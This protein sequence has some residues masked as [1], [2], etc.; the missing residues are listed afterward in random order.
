M[1]SGGNTFMITN[2]ASGTTTMV[3][4]GTGADTVDVQATGGK[5]TVNTGGG[6]NLNVVN[7]GSK[8]PFTGGIVNNIQ[9]A[10]TVVGNGA[11]TMN[12]DDTGSTTAKTGT[13]TAT[14]LTG[15]NMGPSGITYSGLSILNLSLGSGGATGNAF[16]IAVDAG[17]NLPA[18]TNIVGGSAVLDTLNGSWARDFNGTLNLSRFATSGFM[19]GNNFNGALTDINPGYIKSITIGG[20]L[21][22]AATL[23]VN[24]ASDPAIPPTPVGLLGDI[25]TMIVGGSIAGLVEVTGNIT[26]LDVGPANTPTANDVNDVSGRVIAGGS[27]MTASVSGNVSGLIQSNFTVNSLYIGGS[28][29]PSGTFTLPTPFPARISPAQQNLNILTIGSNLAGTVFVPGTLG[30]ASLG[31]SLL[32]TG[33]MSVGNLDSLTIEQDLDGR[34][35]VLGRST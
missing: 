6:A 33:V 8:A 35:D 20:S 15:L 7:V 34:L 11:D 1:G 21:N 27:L 17:T 29:T 25:G 22:A 32:D 30:T 3:N 4:S 18:T 14:T 9:G 13:L 16:N 31:G 26:T 19:V 10:L 2:T 12:V 28:L 23:V 5:T 24:N